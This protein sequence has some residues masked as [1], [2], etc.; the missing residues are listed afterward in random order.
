MDYGSFFQEI[1][2]KNWKDG[3]LI[4][5]ECAFLV[6]VLTQRL[7]RKLCPKCKEK[8]QL[9]DSLREKYLINKDAKIYKAVGCNFCQKTGY[10][11]R[12]S[13]CEYLR[14]SSKLRNLVIGSATESDIKKQGRCEGM[15]TLREDGIVKL[16][17]GITT[18]EEVLKV[19]HSDEPVEGRR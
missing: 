6:G 11:G 2:I 12:I 15:R 7:V 13:L 18:L 5:I 17:N 10:K 1:I 14:M 16:E 19:T 4:P 9:S 8:V 3:I